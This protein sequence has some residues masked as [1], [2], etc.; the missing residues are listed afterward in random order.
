MRRPIAPALVEFLLLTRPLIAQASGEKKAKLQRAWIAASTHEAA[1]MLDVDAA[2]LPQSA[3]AA[4]EALT[5]LCLQLLKAQGMTGVELGQFFNDTVDGGELLS[6]P[7]MQ[8]ALRRGFGLLT[9]LAAQQ[10]QAALPPDEI[11][12]METRHA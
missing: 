8:E 7:D 5:K 3:R 10:M 9:L 1:L 11:E 12:T 2:R 4:T 6:A